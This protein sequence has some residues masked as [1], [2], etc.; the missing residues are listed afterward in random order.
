MDGGA[1]VIA[2]L[3]TADEPRIELLLWILIWSELA[4]FTALLA[5]FTIANV[6][7]PAGFAATRSHLDLGQAGIATAVLLTSGLFAARAP[8]MRHPSRDLLLAAAGGALFCALKISAYLREL[9]LAGAQD[10]RM[11]EMYVLITGFHLVHVFFGT[12]LLAGVAWR[13]SRTAV[14]TVVTIWHVIDLVWITILPV[15]YIG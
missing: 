10:G 13:P 2:R 6:L 4:V 15:V 12:L 11:F 8:R 1:P 14:T 9:P 7:D 5:A 3:E